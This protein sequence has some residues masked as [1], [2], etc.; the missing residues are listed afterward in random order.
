[1]RDIRLGTFFLSLFWRVW[2]KAHRLSEKLFRAIDGAIFIQQPSNLFTAMHNG[3]QK[4]RY[5]GRQRRRCGHTKNAMDLYT[6]Q[7]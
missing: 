5:I 7:V 2:L 3:R 1:M 4:K 6:I